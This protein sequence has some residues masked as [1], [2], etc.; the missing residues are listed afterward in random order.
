MKYR[1]AILHV[2][3]WVA[4][5]LTIA[6]GAWVRVLVAVH[7]PLW[8]DELHTSWVIID[9]W[10][11]VVERAAQGHQT[12]IYFFVVK[13]INDLCGHTEWNLRVLSVVSGTALMG[14]AAWLTW[15]FTASR[16]SAWLAVLLVAIDQTSIFY[17]SE[18]RP[19]ALLQLLALL[20]VGWLFERVLFVGWPSLTAL[21]NLGSRQAAAMPATSD[22]PPTTMDESWGI[23]RRKR[24]TIFFWLAFSALSAVLVF[25][26]PTALLLLAAEVLVVS[27]FGLVS[28]AYSRMGRKRSIYRTGG[29]DW[30]WVGLCLVPLMAVSFWLLPGRA[31][32]WQVRYLWSDITDVGALLTGDLLTLAFVGAVSW[33]LCFMVCGFQ[34]RRLYPHISIA[35]LLF[36]LF[37]FVTGMAAGFD[38]WGIAPLAFSR[39][40]V[41]ALGAGWMS[42]TM[43]AAIRVSRVWMRVAF[44]LLVLFMVPYNVLPRMQGGEW[45]EEKSIPWIFAQV[46]FQQPDC[47]RMRFEDWK[48]ARDEIERI[49]NRNDVPVLLLA[50]LLEN[51]LL[52]GGHELTP[53]QRQSLLD[54]LQFPLKGIY[55]LENPRHISADIMQLRNRLAQDTHRFEEQDDSWAFDWLIVVDRPHDGDVFNVRDRVQSQAH[56]VW[57][58]FPQPGVRAAYS[59]SENR[60]SEF[61][62]IRVSTVCARIPFGL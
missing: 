1:P 39:Y 5:G 43:V 26:H 7:D 54:Y 3:G 29:Q 9:D 17:A 21:T 37:A 16:L 30:L 11:D 40:T 33:L 60:V 42:V 59:N 15:R 10:S 31:D 28:T 51:K 38:D 25:V 8:L 62:G 56:G 57:D 46:V 50:N 34:P 48:S 55:G 47:W 24:P 35:V 14:V 2:G 19:Y 6:V 52:D 49:R 13:L 44:A 27:G 45:Y 41:V 61:E 18:A 20:Q 4:I 22:S 32:T 23:N 58:L 53:S 12:P 36:L